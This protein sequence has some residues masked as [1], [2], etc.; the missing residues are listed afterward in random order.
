M[1]QRPARSLKIGAK[2]MHLKILI[3]TFTFPPNMDGVAQAAASMAFGLAERG[4]EVAV[5]TGRLPLRRDFQPHPRL[6]VRQFDISSLRG[7]DAHAQKEA[8]DMKQWIADENPDVIICHCW[9]IWSTALAESVFHK[10]VAKK[11]LISHGYMAPRWQPNPRPPFGLGAFVRGLPN[12][13]RLPWKLRLYDRV[14]FLSAKN[15]WNRFLDHRIAKLSGYR[16]C[17]VIPN[18]TETDP[19]RGSPELFRQT[20]V[21]GTG[22]V[23]C[24]VAN[25]LAIKNQELALRAFRK[26]RLKDAT[27]ILIG[28]EFNAYSRKLQLLDEQLGKSYPDG[29]VV[30]LEKLDRPT[31]LAAYAVCDLFLLT[32]KTEAQPTVILEAMAAGKPF[33]S[34]DVGCTSELPG[35]IVV[36]RE[37]DLIAAMVAL[38]NDERKRLA[39]G[40]TGR[41]AV[42][43][44]YSKEKVL[45]AQEKMILE[46]FPTPSAQSSAPMK[47]L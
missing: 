23:L 29:T 7:S 33:L 38:Q 46:L 15:D 8:Q 19:E 21:R 2:L 43:E 32:S 34:M 13:L 41:Q 12:I 39:L 17:R 36:R 25:Y 44:A 22:F 11:I 6:R 24:C 9:E 40:A 4:H 1:G 18:G 45:A 27:L 14:V 10:L 35:G 20:H 42:L 30:F 31:T 5:A 47:S 16:G 26:A 37:K 3:T 28:S